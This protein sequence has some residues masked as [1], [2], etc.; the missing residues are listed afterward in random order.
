LSNDKAKPNVE[1]GSEEVVVEQSKV[2][3]EMVETKIEV[4]TSSQQP[5]N[6]T[7]QFLKLDH[8]VSSSSGK[9]MASRTT[10]PRTAPTPHWC[11]PGLTPSQRSRIQHM[12]AQKLREEATKKERDGHFNTIRPMISMK[13][14]W[15]VKEKTN[16]STLMTSDDDMNL[17]DDNESPLIKDGSLPQIDMNINMVF[18]LSPEFRGA[19][20]EVI[21]MCLGSK[22]AVFKKTIVYLGPHR[23]E[24]D[25]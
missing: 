23:W 2:P 18:T 4:G 5:P 24:V 13:Q 15:R 22:D 19:K 14:E 20:E 21:Q 16:T 7:V 9:K 6:Q 8:P 10:A 1:K 3:R 12:R 17:L 11:P 25:L